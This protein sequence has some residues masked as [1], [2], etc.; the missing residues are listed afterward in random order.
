MNLKQLAIVSL[1]FFFAVSLI[2]ADEIN[3][4]VSTNA[5]GSLGG[6]QF[7][8]QL[9]TISAVGDTDNVQT[10]GDVNFLLTDIFVTVAIDGLGSAVFVDAIQ[11]VS[12]NN[13]ELAGFGNTSNSTGLI[14]VN[15][16][17]FETYDLRSEIGPITATAFIN[18][19]THVTDAGNLFLFGETVIGS[20]EASITAVPE[21]SSTFAL[22]ML[23]TAV[24]CRRRKP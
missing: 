19:A 15:D 23:M 16:P 4:V 8:D 2:N 5:S 1:A 13:S 11:A 22:A 24:G 14:F 20:Y 6:V 17:V 3:Y 18:A 21:P 7:T 12:N 10:N 9:V